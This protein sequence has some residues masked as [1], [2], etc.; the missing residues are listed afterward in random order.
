MNSREQIIEQLKRLHEVALAMKWKYATDWIEGV[1]GVVA[2]DQATDEDKLQK[3]RSLSNC[4]CSKGEWDARFAEQGGMS[5]GEQLEIFLR[6]YCCCRDF[7]LS[8]ESESFVEFRIKRDT[9]ML[10]HHEKLTD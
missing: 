1:M 5:L 6:I 3:I 9:E 10:L 2:D 7:D 8:V 4:F